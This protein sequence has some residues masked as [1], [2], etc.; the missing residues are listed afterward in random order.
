MSRPVYML[1]TNTCSF[2]IRKRPEYL[3]EK[4]QNTVISGHSVVI[5][6]ITYAELT[7]GAINKQAS[8]KMPKIVSEFVSRL[9]EVLAWDK[10]AVK[11]ATEIKKILESKGTPIGH[12]DTLIAGHCIS[13][14]AIL[15]TD[16]VH[17]FKRVKHLNY[18]NWVER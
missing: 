9:D 16:N 8:P 2:L 18:E 1:D 4:L 12:N 14:N 7:F 13:N 10:K 6:S 11:A 3:L 17:E 5:S 15:V